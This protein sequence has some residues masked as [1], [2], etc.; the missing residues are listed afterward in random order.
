V[1]PDGAIKEGAFGIGP[2]QFVV[3]EQGNLKIEV[4]FSAAKLQFE[5]VAAGIVQSRG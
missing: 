4:P 1:V 5:L 2:Q 3:A